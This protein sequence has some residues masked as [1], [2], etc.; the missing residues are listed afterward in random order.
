MA[1]QTEHGISCECG[2]PEICRIPYT[3]SADEFDAF[4][5]AH[6][7]RMNAGRSQRSRAAEAHLA[8]EMKEP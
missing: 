1:A 5:Q 7:S 3:G 8:R 6:P 4:V 2:A